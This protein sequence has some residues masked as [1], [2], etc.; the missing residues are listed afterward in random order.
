MD[1]PFSFCSLFKDDFVLFCQTGFVLFG[2]EPTYSHDF[3]IDPD[4]KILPSA[5]NGTFFMTYKMKQRNKRNDSCPNYLIPVTMQIDL[6]PLKHGLNI[7][8]ILTMIMSDHFVMGIDFGTDSVRAVL[9]NALTG[10]ER[11]ST[12]FAIPALERSGERG[13]RTFLK[14]IW[15]SIL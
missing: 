7:S 1:V 9:L 10:E 15:K 14:I 2:E 11:A 6:T 5:P 3:L 12:G 8:V 13:I 4:I